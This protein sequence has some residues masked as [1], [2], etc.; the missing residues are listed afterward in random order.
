MPSASSN[1]A[2]KEFARTSFRNWS[3]RRFPGRSLS[4]KLLKGLILMNFRKLLIRPEL[5]ACFATILVFIVFAIIAGQQG[6]L[7]AQGTINYLE[8]GAQLGIL[9]SAVALLMIAGEFD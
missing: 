5:G 9:A 3:E 2:R 1:S 6:F 4:S 7:S 8:V